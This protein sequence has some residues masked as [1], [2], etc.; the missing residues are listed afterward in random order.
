MTPF[1]LVD[2]LLLGSLSSLVVGSAAIFILRVLKRNLRM[3]WLAAFLGTGFSWLFLVLARSGIPHE[4]QFTIWMPVNI[5]DLAHASNIP[6]LLLDNISWT[7]ALVLS[8][9]ALSVILTDVS[10]LVEESWRFWFSTILIT[11]L[12]VL[13]ALAGNP[14]TFILA[15][16]ALDLADFV[17]SILNISGDPARRQ[18]FISLVTR[19]SGIFVM[20]GVILLADSQTVLLTFDMLLPRFAP[21]ILLAV[22][23]RLIYFIF[24]KSNLYEQEIPLGLG[25]AV[26]ITSIATCLVLIVRVAEVGISAEWMP[27]LL[28][29]SLVL[30]IYL[31]IRWVMS[32]NDLLGRPFWLMSLALITFVSAIVGNVAA[33]LIFSVSGLLLIGLQNLARI[34]VRNLFIF[35]VLG[36]FSIS[37]LPFSPTWQTASL[38]TYFWNNISFPIAFIATFMGILGL[39]LL[40]L[41]YLRFGLALEMGEINQERWIWLL[42]IPGLAL[43][44]LTNYAVG[45]SNLPDFRNLPLF[46]WLVGGLICGLTASMIFYTRRK[47]I[48]SKFLINDSRLFVAIKDVG[49]LGIVNSLISLILKTI[50]NI[51]SILNFV[52]EGE[53]GLLWSYLFLVML[54]SLALQLGLNR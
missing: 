21:L 5:Q 6:V 50:G 2:L 36:I 31:A 34:R 22:L 4:I 18:V 29:L 48:L 8:T 17:I 44:L 47:N 37:M 30:L 1:A 14:F 52:L 15:W 25:T 11:L 43:L 54:I 24:Q 12:G 49:L 28:I 26:R 3:M 41:G 51:I 42:Y 35:L 33:S 9:I 19:I 45:W 46:E 39:S 16:T 7:F 32:E 38:F 23:L 27:V 53:G 40:F 13:A 10:R 20:I